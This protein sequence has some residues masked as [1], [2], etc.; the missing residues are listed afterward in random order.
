MFCKNYC[1]LSL[2]TNEKENELTNNHKKNK[3]D[4]FFKKISNIFGNLKS[5]NQKDMHIAYVL[6]SFPIHSETFVLNEVKY[7][8]ENGYNIVVFIRNESHKPVEL[9][10][11]VEIVKFDNAS[12][13]SELLVKYNIE[14][15]HTHFV[16]PICTTLTYPVAS[17]LKIPFTVFTHAYDIFTKENDERNKIKEISESQYCKGIFTLSEFHKNYLMERGVAED[18]I[19][20]TKQATGYEL[21][22]IKTKEKPIKR[23][24]S[25]SR[26]VEKK[27]LDVLIN[28]AKILENEDFVF[29]IYGFGRL[30]NDLKNQIQELNCKN[31]SIKG[32]L[33]PNEVRNVLIDSDL[34]VSPCKVARNGD[35]DG[36]PTVIFES[37]AVGLP[38]LTTS[39]SAIPEIIQDH[40]NGF[41]TEPNNPEK[42]A[43]KI[44]EV[45]KVPYEKM[46]TIRK[47]AQKDVKNISSVE[48]TMKTYFKI[49]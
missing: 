31:I 12:E 2:D 33:Q 18:K 34:L 5:K 16:Y 4:T 46:L 48:K 10:F 11:N 22:K 28:A 27:G 7:L 49:W 9:D 23:I 43:D 1:E 19:I 35:M 25:V 37:M 41:I 6:Y 30:E 26:F 32:E 14:L 8:K 21:S 13:L 17:K 40:V 15:V 24:V 47:Q 38:I 20:I 44:L 3:K 39:V 45:S 42:F 36:F 29:E